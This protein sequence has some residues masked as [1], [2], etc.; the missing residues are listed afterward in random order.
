MDRAA[1]LKHHWLAVHNRIESAS[2][3]VG[4]NPDT[5]TCL[6]VSK[7]KPLSDIEHLFAAGQRAFGE[8][9]VQE[10]VEKITAFTGKGVAWHF[11]GA[12]QSNK[13]QVIA[14]H[15]DW[16]HTIDRAKI[17]HRLNDARS[18]NPLNVLIQVNVDQAPSKAGVLPEALDALVD[19]I[20]KCPN[21]QLHGLMSIPDPVNDTALQ[22]AHQDLHALFTKTRAGLKDPT[23]FDTLS[24]GMTHDLE[25]AIAEGSTLVR[26]GTALFGAR[27]PKETV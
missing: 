4:R 13:T 8:N 6:A 16:V 14:Q 2:A 24:M 11:I 25:L 5:V 26:I 17:A 3:S 19:E 21:L 22:R 23:H 10:A 27:S 7:T 1:E 9:Y 15:F 12:I 18:G 20:L